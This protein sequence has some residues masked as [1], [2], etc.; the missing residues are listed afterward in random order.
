M[1]N[2]T[3]T[4]FALSTAPGRGGIAVIRV[5]G[6]NALTS[7]QMLTDTDQF[8]PNNIAL[9]KITNPVSHETIDQAMAVYFK[10]PHS[11]TG[12]DTIEYHIHGGK[13]VT[14][15][16]LQ[17]LATQPNHRL[18][19]PGEFTRRAF[20]NGKL[21]LTEAEAVADLIDAETIA[22]KNQALTQL[23][24]A[25]SAL[26]QNW[27]ETLK[28]LLAHTEAD[29]EFP[30]E[31]LPDGFSQIIKPQIENLCSEIDAHLNDN[32]RGERL[33]DGIQVAIIGAPNAGKSS[34]INALTQRDVAIVSDVAGTT[35]D[36]I[37]AHLDL[38]GYPVTLIDTAGL[39]TQHAA[40]Q[41]HDKIENEGMRRAIERAE[42]A[43]LKILI[44]D[45]NTPEPDEITLN[46]KTE[47]DIILIN[48][49][50]QKTTLNIPNAL[51][52][53]AQVGTGIPQFLKTLTAKVE[54]L[55]GTNEQ[56]SLTRQRHRTALQHCHEDLTRSLNAPLPELAAEDLRQG[57]RSLGQITGKIGVE[58]LLDT[59]FNDFCIGK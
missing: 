41:G 26:Y 28:T 20:E 42:N 31:D 23:S 9:Y 43:D 55:I 37:E 3:D 5:S 19:E 33:R 51:K 58:D 36:V 39:R 16:L 59:I 22:Q 17:T 45:G 49:I 4:I 10:A 53:S 44:F 35:R 46:L 29:L 11:Y 57:I 12:E 18:A 25:L 52:I 2:H 38:G 21:D 1:N 14:T 7:A 54:S 40:A 13:A 56:P 24:G 15:E 27:T 30:D 34:L 50:D 47:N 32:R 48:K 6:N 8:T